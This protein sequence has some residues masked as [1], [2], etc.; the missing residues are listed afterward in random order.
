MKSTGILRPVDNLDRIVIPKELCN[1]LGIEPKTPM[2][3]FVK[4]SKIV[5]KKHIFDEGTIKGSTG[6][7]RKVD[8]LDRIVIPKEMCKA[9]E[10]KPKTR[11]EIFV[12]DEMIILSK[13]ENGC[14]FC[15]AEDNLVEYKAKP[16]CKACLKELKGLE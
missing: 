7:V 3:I 9:M 10:I 8:G 13:C 16:V 1:T 12:E 4:E 14:I 2:E 6:I 5:L 11:L 15:G